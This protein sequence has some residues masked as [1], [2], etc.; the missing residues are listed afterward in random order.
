MCVP[1]LVGISCNYTVTLTNP[2]CTPLIVYGHTPLS[3][4][5]AFYTCSH[6]QDELE[7]ADTVCTL[8]YLESG[9]PKCNPWAKVF[10]P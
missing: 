5:T 1:I 10:T 4:T 7:V 6:Y 8:I 2:L 3:G 9:C